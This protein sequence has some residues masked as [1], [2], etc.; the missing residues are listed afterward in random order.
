MSLKDIYIIANRDIR[1][2]KRKFLIFEV[3]L[4]T[5]V[6]CVLLFSMLSS[7]VVDYILKEVNSKDEY[8]LIT[9]S[10]YESGEKI[11]NALKS[12]QYIT[13]VC[14]EKIVDE[15]DK[16][17]I[18]DTEV[19]T[20]DVR[21]A[22]TDNDIFVGNRNMTSS[23][24]QCGRNLKKNDKNK[25]LIDKRAVNFLGYNKMEDIL[26]KKVLLKKD[27]IEFECEI[28]GV[29]FQETESAE[30]L[31][32]EA[33]RDEAGRIDIGVESIVM[34]LPQNDIISDEKYIVATVDSVENV[35]EAISIVEDSADACVYSEMQNVN[36]I[37]VGFSKIRQALIIIAIVLIIVSFITIISVLYVVI[38]SNNK[39][40]KLL[41]IIGYR[42][43]LIK[44]INMMEIS[45]LTIKALFIGSIIS[46]FAMVLL[47]NLVRNSIGLGNMFA[48][49]VKSFAILGGSVLIVCNGISLLFTTKILKIGE[50]D[51]K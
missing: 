16:V 10:E 14:E 49:P 46:F 15:W 11:I 6:L 36:S 20:A 33:F 47:N 31:S 23:I 45:M 30:E 29:F 39:W 35:P 37:L 2:K 41:N 7:G 17:I 12:Q 13:S 48:Y 44:V 1:N 25:V 21:L 26:G 27:E 43:S 24:I 40:Y 38:E 32:E 19:V 51:E 4:V 18:D 22:S 34:P 5:S 3:S 42:N 8:K 28:V 9:I 50:S